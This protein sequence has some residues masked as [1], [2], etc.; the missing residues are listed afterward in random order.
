MVKEELRQHFTRCQGQRDAPAPLPTLGD[1]SEDSSEGLLSIQR[2]EETDS[3]GGQ[4]AEGPSRTLRGTVTVV[5][6]QWREATRVTGRALRLRAG[7]HFAYQVSQ[8]HS[9]AM[10]N[11]FHS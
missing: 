8:K 6:G 11:H 3:V 2:W 1:G 9:S 10:K 4:Q 7:E 5:G